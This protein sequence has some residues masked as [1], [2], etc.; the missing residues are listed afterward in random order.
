MGRLP[1][2]SPLFVDSPRMGAILA[3]SSLLWKSSADHIMS[4][5]ETVAA[6]AV[7]S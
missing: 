3:A 2:I 1:D 4:V 7:S 5:D 6:A